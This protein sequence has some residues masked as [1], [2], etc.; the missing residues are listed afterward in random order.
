MPV[1]TAVTARATTASRIDHLARPGS[2]SSCWPGMLN[3]KTR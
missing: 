3:V 2:S 1:A